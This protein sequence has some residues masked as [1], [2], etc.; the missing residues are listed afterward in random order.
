MT[1]L[2]ATH[3]TTRE[4]WLALHAVEAHRAVLYT[5]DREWDL[6]RQVAG[7]AREY[8]RRYLH[9]IAYPSA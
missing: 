4:Y 9:R 7:Y 2:L 3:M 8:W 1:P 5:Y 6:A